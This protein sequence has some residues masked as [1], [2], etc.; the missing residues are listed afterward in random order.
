MS[1]VQCPITPGL[2]VFPISTVPTWLSHSRQGHPGGYS[3]YRDERR[4]LHVNRAFASAGRPAP[5]LRGGGFSRRTATTDR[6]RA[7]RGSRWRRGRIVDGRRRLEDLP[8]R[9]WKGRR[10]YGGGGAKPR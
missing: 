2:A 4:R 5:H 8:A 10:W 9:G 6:A 1:F 7:R 3:L